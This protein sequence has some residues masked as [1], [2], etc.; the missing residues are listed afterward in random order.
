M[1]SSPS[2]P[3]AQS[4]SYVLLRLSSPTRRHRR[5]VPSV[6]H[7]DRLVSLP[8][9]LLPASSPRHRS[10]E[11]SHTVA[12]FFRGRLKFIIDNSAGENKRQ[13]DLAVSPITRRTTDKKFRR[14][15]RRSAQLS[16]DLDGRAPRV[17][18]GV[19]EQRA[20]LIRAAPAGVPCQKPADRRSSSAPRRARAAADRARTRR[21]RRVYER[22]REREVREG[23]HPLPDSGESER[24]FSHNPSRELAREGRSSRR[25]S[26]LERIL[27]SFDRAGCAQSSRSTNES[28]GGLRAKRFRTTIWLYERVYVM[29]ELH[30]NG[31]LFRERFGGISERDG[32][33]DRPTKRKRRKRERRAARERGEN[34]AAGVS[35]HA[36]F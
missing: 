6:R 25:G 7:R 19:W 36:S 9:S 27:R 23:K 20:R 32:W 24:D 1:P 5:A 14:N 29:S 10:P 33:L 17:P 16:C 3:P 8:N 15:S 21:P 12:Q 34:R 26:P 31:A 28:S 22:G 11:Y 13:L 4:R 18:P 35:S 30:Y 2:L